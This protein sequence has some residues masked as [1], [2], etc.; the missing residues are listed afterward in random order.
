MGCRFCSI[1]RVYGHSVRHFPLERVLE[2]LR[3]VQA[4]GAR[5][6][7]LV[8]D[9]IT[10]DVTRLKELCRLI[11][12]ERLNGMA[13]LMQASVPGIAAD[14]ELA[15]LL[16]RAGFRWVFLGIESGIARNLKGLGKGGAPDGARRA[17]AALQGQGIC[18]FGGFI[19]GHPDDTREDIEA[20]Y[21][22]ALEIGVDHP[23]MQCLTPYPKTET[24]KELLA[25]GLVT[26]P[27]DYSRYNG[28][29]CNVRTRHLSERELS[30]AM[31]WS[32]LKLYFHPRYLARSRFWR[33]HP[34]LWPDLA[35]NNLRYLSGAARGRI[36]ASPHTW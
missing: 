21:R 32:G 34:A 27:C 8:D 17:V 24:R 28:F 6:V 29:T 14:P 5:G 23:I 31:L 35:A 2:D 25:G 3:R 33:F 10:L 22:Y 15:P 1:A 9:N 16:G 7:F 30:R 20:T 36:F 26:N 4:R 19:V 13:Y 12:R 18:V 11:I